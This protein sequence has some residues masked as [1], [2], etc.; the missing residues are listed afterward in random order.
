MERRC[1]LGEI[2]GGEEPWETVDSEKQTE[3]F[4]VGG[5][6]EPGG[7]YYGGYVLHGALGVVHKQ[8]ILEHWK[9]LKNKKNLKKEYG[10]WEVKI[11]EVQVMLTL[12]GPWNSTRYL[13]N[14]SEHLQNQL[15]I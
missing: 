2:G 7:G 10:F 12:S 3:S 15:D 5:L 6:G 11:A 9:K 1:E 13:S 14:H 4:G 8:W